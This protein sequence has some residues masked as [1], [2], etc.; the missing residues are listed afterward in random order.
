MDMDI[1]LQ[2]LA[3]NFREDLWK[4]QHHRERLQDENDS[5]K[6][7]FGE[8]ERDYILPC[9]KWAKEVGLD[10]EEAVRK[11]PGKNCV[12][13]LVEWLMAHQRPEA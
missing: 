1:D 4:I 8:Y 9:F 2:L 3:Q 13:L 12:E 7:T 11:N 10:L 6:R 5:L